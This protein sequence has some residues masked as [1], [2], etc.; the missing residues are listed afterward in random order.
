[1]LPIQQTHYRPT[2]IS[3]TNYDREVIALD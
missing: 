3:G 2:F 1:M